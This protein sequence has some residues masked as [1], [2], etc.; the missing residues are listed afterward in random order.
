MSIC[1]SAYLWL[2]YVNGKVINLSIKGVVL[3]LG[4]TKLFLNIFEQKK[5]TICSSRL[6][7]LSFNLTFM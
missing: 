5:T 7:T 1:L 4:N 6:P 3:D 2:V